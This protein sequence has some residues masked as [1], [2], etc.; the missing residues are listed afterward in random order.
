ML[1]GEHLLLSL[2]LLQVS[3]ALVASSSHITREAR[4]SD[5]NVVSARTTKVHVW[6]RFDLFPLLLWP[7]D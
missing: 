2:F 1:C 4:K 7:L 5:S 6:S 3:T